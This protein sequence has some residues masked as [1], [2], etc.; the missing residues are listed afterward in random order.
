MGLDDKI[1]NAAEK[2][3]GQA[4]ES[5]GKAT[6]DEQLQAEGQVDQTSAGLKKVGEDVKDVFK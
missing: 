4:K 5:T 1:S 6:G 2:L 3:G